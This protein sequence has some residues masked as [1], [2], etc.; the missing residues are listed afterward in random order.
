MC[1]ICFTSELKDEACVQL[2]CGHV[3]HANC[4]LKLLRHRW[5]TLKISFGF[6]CCPSCKKPITESRSKVIGA[7]LKQLNAF[8]Q[9]VEK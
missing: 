3:F 7:E 2:G 9:T 1:T 8:K 4:I 5:S 6:M